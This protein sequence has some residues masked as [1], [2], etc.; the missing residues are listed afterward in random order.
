MLGRVGSGGTESAQ[1]SR[2]SGQARVAIGYERGSR[3]R[4]LEI[5]FF[6]SFT[7]KSFKSLCDRD[8]VPHW[9]SDLSSVPVSLLH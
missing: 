1:T 2:T 8:P 9:L 6:I 3:S 4:V 5:S 7:V